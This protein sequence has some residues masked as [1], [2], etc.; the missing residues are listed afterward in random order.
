MVKSALER[1]GDHQVAR[2]RRFAGVRKVATTWGRAVV[3]ALAFAVQLTIL[4]AAITYL[5]QWSN[6]I[7]AVQMVLG[8]GVVLY[9]VNQRMETT[10]K[11]AWVIPVLIAPIFGTA[12]YLLFGF[13]RTTRKRKRLFEEALARATEAI[14]LVDGAAGLEHWGLAPE[15]GRQITYLK[16]ASHYTAFDATDTAYYPVGEEAFEAMLEA[17][18]RAERY[19]FAEYFIVAEGVMLDRL[20][21]ALAAKAAE[22]LDVRF[23]YDD[24]GSF[25]KLPVGFHDRC[26]ELGI[27]AVAVNPVG[28]GF[29]LNFQSR[30]HRKILVVDGEVAF[31]GGINIAD[32]YINENDR[33]GHW[34]D[35]VVRLTGPGAWGFTVMF[36]HMWDLVTRGKVDYPSFVPE[37]SSAGQLPARQDQGLV[38][39]FDDSPFDDVSLG[40]DVH[41]QL[42]QAA[43]RS[44]DIFTP[45]LIVNDALIEQLRATAKSGIRVRIV[46]PHIPDK[47]YVHIVTRS[48]YRLLI[49]AGIEI[50]EYTPGFIHA[51]SMLVDDDLAVIG[52]INMDFRSLF[53]HQECAVWLHQTPGALEGLRRDVEETLA[54][55]QRITEDNLDRGLGKTALAAVLGVF[56]PLM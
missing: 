35:T 29:T 33:L 41:Q 14:P 13:R 39:P 34:K 27:S 18:G 8:M 45:Y 21:D 51:K 32:E 38:A 2:S 25:F 44:V 28:L 1:A 52:T 24:L 20:L 9:I 11:L 23:L 5:S 43:T 4:L 12:F 17:I 30:N 40:L 42:L 26:K 37:R 50:Y 48:Y 6:W 7:Y 56:A 15:V 53:L 47:W 55:S 36:L 16:T 10:Y 54:V 46:T 22:G 31:T 3:I 49:D 19:V